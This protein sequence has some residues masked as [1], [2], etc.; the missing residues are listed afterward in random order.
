MNVGVIY[1]D[2]LGKIKYLNKEAKRLTGAS[3][4]EAISRSLNELSL[5]KN[6]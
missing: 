2:F 3:D 6:M 1:T 4:Q 5:L